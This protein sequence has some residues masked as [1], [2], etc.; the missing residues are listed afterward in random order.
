MMTKEEAH[1]WLRD[2][3]WIDRGADQTVAVGTCAEGLY[4]TLDGNFTKTHLQAL[5]VL[6]EHKEQTLAAATQIV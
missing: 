1:A 3:A 4:V 6:I 2:A 5:L